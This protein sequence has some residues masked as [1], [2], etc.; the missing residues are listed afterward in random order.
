MNVISSNG[1]RKI[2]TL[3]KNKINPSEF[4]QC[5]EL[6]FDVVV[7][8]NSTYASGSGEY[9]IPVHPDYMNLFIIP[10]SIS[11]TTEVVCDS[12][13]MIT[14]NQVALRVTNRSSTKKE[15]KLS[16]LLFRIKNNL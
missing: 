5:I 10:L 12:I 11:S 13:R 14:E 7:N 6:N 15:V 2:F 3:L 4:I 9:Y 1:L 8:A 16:A